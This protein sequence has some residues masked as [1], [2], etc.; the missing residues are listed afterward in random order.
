[1]KAANCIPRG[2]L[3]RER[4]AIAAGLVRAGYTVTDGDRGDSDLVV[5]W[6]G[7]PPHGVKLEG[8]RVLVAE[9]GYLSPPGS[10]YVALALGGHNGSGRSP[11]GNTA[12]LARLG[13]PLKPW[14]TGGRY[15]LVCPSRGFGLGD[16]RQPR[17]WTERVAAILSRHSSKP[18]RVRRHPGNWKARPPS[19]PVEDD[20]RDASACVIWAS[21]AGLRALFAG[22]PVIR[23][24]P[25]WIAQGADG[26]RLD[27]IDS[28][29]KP[30]REPALAKMAA[31]QWTF[32]EIAYGDAVRATLESA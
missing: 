2:E 8:R 15:V 1:V 21:S 13:M 11:E 20:L 12:R 14:R 25:H 28:P 30:D 19:I 7:S 9:N 5:I 16:M 18:I 17:D 22:V 24:A 23:C 29:P 32:D 10:Q 4:A 6:N 26:T 27:D 3:S 31:A